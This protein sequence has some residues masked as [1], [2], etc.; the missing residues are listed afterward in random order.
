MG[1]YSVLRLGLSDNFYL[2]GYSVLRLVLSD[3]FHLGGILYSDLDSLTI[4][5]GGRGTTTPAGSCITDSLSHVETNDDVSHRN[6]PFVTT[7]IKGF[8]CEALIM[9]KSG[10]I[11]TYGTIH[12]K[13]DISISFN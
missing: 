4:F 3:N 13:L 2:G 6:A 11:T 10:M 12:L 1:G 8:L 9:G 5:I 7:R